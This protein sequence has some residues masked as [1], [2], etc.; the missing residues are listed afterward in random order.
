[1]EV[2]GSLVSKCLQT[3]LGVSRKQLSEGYR[4]TGDLG[5]AAAKLFTSSNSISKNFFSSTKQVD[6]LSIVTLIQELDRIV[7]TSGRDAKQRRVTQLLRKCQTKNEI[8]FLVRLLVSNMRVGCNLKTVLAALAMATC[9]SRD[10]TKATIA[11]VQKTHDICPDLYKITLSLLQGGEGQMVEECT[12]Q[13]LTPISPMLA[14]PIHSLDQVEKLMSESQERT[15]LEWKYDGVRCQAHYDGTKLKL[16]SRHMLDT[17]EQYPDAAESILDAFRQQTK[18]NS[19]ASAH[20]FILDA[21]IVGVEGE[22]SSERLLPFQDLSRRKKTHDGQGVR[23]K[24]FAFDLMYL[25]GSSLVNASLLER[26]QK[27]HASFACTRDFDFVTSY[28]ID[29]FDEAKIQSYLKE[30]VAG[31]TEGLMLKLLGTSEEQKQKQ[32][33]TISAGPKTCY[34]A[35]TRSQSW[36]K[37]KRDYVEGYA[38]TIDV[39]PIGAWRGTGRKAQKKFLS[40]ILLGVYDEKE[41][42]FRSISRCMS[43]TDKMYEAIREFYLNGTPYP[44]DLGYA[45]GGSEHQSQDKSLTSAVLQDDEDS[46]LS[47]PQVD[48][49]S[50]E[51]SS[52]GVHCYASRPSSAHIVTNESPPIWF[53]PMEVFEVSFADMSLSRQHTAAAGLIDDP[54]GRGVALRFPRFKRRRPDKTIEQATSCAQI[55]Q[56]FSQQSKQSSRK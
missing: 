9:A 8:R 28:T 31:G 6:P 4:A 10:D 39:V 40:P 12:I 26:K 18:N 21:E 5:D 20:S 44:D 49:S 15:V 14:N 46:N 13:L 2:S 43:F 25:N 42:V 48:P 53:K 51:E 1:M 11:L 47:D 54:E 33:N 56:L 16:F 35:G 38:D 23:V 36:L 55:A 3:I 32:N 34:E 45:D 41:D 7:E 22:G 37:I 30:S 19:L 27:L 50:M 17:T 52:V 24:V 29:Q